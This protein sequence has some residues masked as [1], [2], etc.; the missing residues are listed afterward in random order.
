MKTIE[1]CEKQ[2]I[3][4]RRHRENVSSKENNCGKFLAILKLLAQTNEYLQ[5]HLTLPV[6][7]N[8]TY[9]SPKIQN[10]INNIIVL[11]MIF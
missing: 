7:N 5:N 2:C 10:E 8:A 1:L 11:I 6:A 4:F 9:L 3:A